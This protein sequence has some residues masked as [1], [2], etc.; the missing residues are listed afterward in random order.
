MDNKQENKSSFPFPAMLLIAA[1]I[2]G[3]VFKFYVPL[4]SMRPQSGDKIA[5]LQLGEERVL[6]RMWQD[7]FQAV[8]RHLQNLKDDNKDSSIS[9]QPKT[10]KQIERM[11]IMPVLT[12]AGN[13][14]QKIER[15]LNRM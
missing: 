9:F 5:K 14:A 2:A 11:L 7:P 1:V 4:D 12:T 15:R 6:A 10:G 3:G 8:E 13:Y